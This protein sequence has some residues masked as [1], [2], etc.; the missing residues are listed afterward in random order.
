MVVYINEAKL[1]YKD[2]KKDPDIEKPDK[3]SHN[4]W[5]AWEEIVYTHF[6]A[7]KNIRGIS[8]FTHVLRKTPYWSI[9]NID[10]EQEIINNAPPHGNM[11]SRDT[12]KVL[13]ILKDLTVHNDDETWMKGKLCGLE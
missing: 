10:G 11:F 8:P 4:K 12:K 5:V 13:A 3:I 9:I 1:D 2:G 6:T 7:M